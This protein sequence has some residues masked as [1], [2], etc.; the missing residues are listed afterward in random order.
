MTPL[1]AHVKV[2]EFSRYIPLPKVA[3][4]IGGCF[5][6][7]GGRLASLDL[8]KEESLWAVAGEA[9]ALAL[10]HREESDREKAKVEK[11]TDWLKEFWITPSPITGADSVAAEKEYRLSAT[12]LINL[13]KG[14]GD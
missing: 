3:R 6:V 1:E 8:H 2:G 4:S 10:K 13:V 14:L 11:V 5:M 7:T 9:I 12:A